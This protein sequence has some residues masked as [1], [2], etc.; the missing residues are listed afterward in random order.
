[1]GEEACRQCPG[2]IDATDV[3]YRPCDCG[4][5]VCVWCWWRLQMDTMPPDEVRCQGCQKKLDVR[6]LL[7]KVDSRHNVLP[8]FDAAALPRPPAS[9]KK[10]AAAKVSQSFLVVNRRTL[11]LRGLPKAAASDELLRGAEHCAKY[12]T[13]VGKV[14]VRAMDRQKAPP[15]KQSSTGTP[16]AAQVAYEALVTYTTRG[17]AE[18]AIASLN[19]VSYMGRVL[20]ASHSTHRL[21]PSLIRKEKCAAAPCA[22][23]HAVPD[24]AA[25]VNKLQSV[26][27]LKKTLSAPRAAPPPAPAAVPAAA[28]RQQAPPPFPQPAAQQDAPTT[29][30]QP[31]KPSSAGVSY[32][33]LVAAKSKHAAAAAATA[34][35]QNPP[36]KQQTAPPPAQPPLQQTPP[37]QPQ[38]QQQQ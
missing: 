7:A 11:H 1:M 25:V 29:P 17:A 14:L 27:F 2:L 18:A 21:C 37:P 23:L 13:I 26:A 10:G 28:G 31:S 4:W 6:R 22:S 16:A 9:D 20:R 38:Q 24:D 30:P 15:S 35:P 36:K 12:G 34:A 32:A 5:R 3:E 19:H 33:S 8:P